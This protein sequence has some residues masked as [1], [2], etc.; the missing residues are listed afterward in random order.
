VPAGALDDR[1]TRTKTELRI[2]TVTDDGLSI[3]SHFGRAASYTVTTVE[4]GR[5]V[6]RGLRDKMGHAHSVG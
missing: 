3:S 6:N 4:N 2:A 1:Q 5:V